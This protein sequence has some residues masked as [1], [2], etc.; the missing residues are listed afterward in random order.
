MCAPSLQVAKGDAGM[1]QLILEKVSSLFQISFCQL[2]RDSKIYVVI[3]CLKRLARSQVNLYFT[4]LLQKPYH[5]Q[6]VRYSKMLHRCLGL[7]DDIQSPVYYY[8]SV[9]M[10]SPFLNGS[11]VDGC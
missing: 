4:Y 10:F 3:V 1:T 7:T 2:G 9:F 8:E 6:I 5:L 11:K